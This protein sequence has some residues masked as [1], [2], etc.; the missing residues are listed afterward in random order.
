MVRH[1]LMVVV[2]GA[3]TVAGFAPATQALE[4]FVAPPVA[5]LLLAQAAPAANAPAAQAAPAAD[6]AAGQDAFLR[7][8]GIC[9]TADKGGPDRF[10]PNLFAVV[11]KQAGTEANFA[12]SAAF[13][14]AA[15]WKWDA[16]LL[17]GWISNPGALIPGT[18]MAVY[19]GVADKDRDNIIAYLASLK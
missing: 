2:A 12:Y 8:C 7:Q 11:G 6:P 9:H 3:G 13:K 4:A 1:T 14:K 17:G 18:A 10:G 16:A 19:Q 5:G 15:T